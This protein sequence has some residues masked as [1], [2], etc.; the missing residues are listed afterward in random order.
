MTSR[1]I[2]Q[3]PVCVLRLCQL[4]ELK[5]TVSSLS[6]DVVG[7]AS[8]FHLRHLEI[9]V[10][11]TSDR[12]A[13]LDASFHQHADALMS[14]FHDKRPEAI[15]QIRAC[16]SMADIRSHAAAALDKCQPKWTLQMYV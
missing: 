12:I 10:L 9:G 16:E 14:A 1:D 11:D 6:A 7:L 4:E 8:W 5:L 15:M 2:A 3:F 13:E